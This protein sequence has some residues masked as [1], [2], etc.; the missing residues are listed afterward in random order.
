MSILVRRK[1]YIVLAGTQFY[2]LL[3][4][5]SFL[6]HTGQAVEFCHITVILKSPFRSLNGIWKDTKSY[7]CWLL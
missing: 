3:V 2:Y 7:G 1:Y 6:T 4:E 5:Q